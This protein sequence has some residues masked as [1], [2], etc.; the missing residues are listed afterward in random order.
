M[1]KILVLLVTCVLLLSFTACNSTRWGKAEGYLNGVPKY[2]GEGTVGEFQTVDDNPV[3]T[4]IIYN[5]S[6][7]EYSAYLLTLEKDGFTLTE[8][9]GNV[10]LY[11][12]DTLDLL[13]SYSGDS[14]MIVAS[15]TQAK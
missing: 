13:I 9:V 14:L 1:K 10:R 11:Q 5:V 4:V 12:K 15:Q 8:E 3:T 6:E 2:T 7:E